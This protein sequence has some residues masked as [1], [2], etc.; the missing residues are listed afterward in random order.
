[1]E[2]C[3]AWYGRFDLINKMDR[4]Y[5]VIQL[6]LLD[7]VKLV[8]KIVAATGLLGW[9]FSLNG[10]STFILIRIHVFVRGRGHTLIGWTFV[11][12]GLTIWRC[13]RMLAMIGGMRNRSEIE[14]V[15]GAS[16]RI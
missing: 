13:Q 11:L 16:H 15:R 4:D 9:V 8:L 5:S 3:F 10:V 6:I 2:V 7:E 14:L 12:E 1:M